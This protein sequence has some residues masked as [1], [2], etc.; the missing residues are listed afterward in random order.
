METFS[1]GLRHYS[2]PEKHPMVAKSAPTYKK[3]ESMMKESEDY[4][5]EEGGVFSS[6]CRKPFFHLFLINK[7]RYPKMTSV[8][9]PIRSRFS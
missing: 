6:L 2:L 1:H 5:G 7:T 4:C 3:A 9:I 8:I